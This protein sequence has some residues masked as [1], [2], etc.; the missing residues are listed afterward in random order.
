[1]QILSNSGAATEPED[2]SILG[3]SPDKRPPQCLLGTVLGRGCKT[4]A[5]MTLD[6]SWR[7]KEVKKSR[8]Q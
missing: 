6:V 2:P 7:F 8:V 3:S 1:M 5:D 4:D